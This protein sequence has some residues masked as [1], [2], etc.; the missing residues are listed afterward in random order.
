MPCSS[1]RAQARARVSGAQPADVQR[2]PGRERRAARPRR[3]GRARRSASAP[4][5]TR[6]GPGRPRMPDCGGTSDS[7]RGAIGTGA[8]SR[9][10][11]GHRRSGRSLK[12]SS[13]VRRPQVR[14]KPS[15]TECPISGTGTSAAP[16]IRA[17][18]RRADS[19]GVR[20]SSSPAST[21]VG[22]AGNGPS[23]IAGVGG[24]RRPAAAQLDGRRGEQ[25]GRA[26][27]GMQRG[28]RQRPERGFR[29]RR[30][31]PRRGVVRA[32]PSGPSSQ[33]VAA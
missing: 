12:K 10:R 9:R 7:E 26:V 16:G 8:N 13:T 6:C 1:R 5:R 33:T 17:A 19:S 3:S 15:S 22:T 4:P 32:Q 14:G 18:M 27:E 25:R 20:R 24:R 28:R 29:G 11:G 23:W 21:S 2:R 31:A 30:R